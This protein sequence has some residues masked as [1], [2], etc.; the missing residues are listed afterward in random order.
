VFGNTAFETLAS[1]DQTD[2][3]DD[4][5]KHRK[6][7]KNTSSDWEGRYNATLVV[8]IRR[9]HIEKGEIFELVGF[10]GID[11]MKPPDCAPVFCRENRARLEL[12]DILLGYAD[13]I[14]GILKRGTTYSGPN[15]AIPGDYRVDIRNLE[16]VSSLHNFYL[17]RDIPKPVSKSASV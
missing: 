12:K 14:Y 13:N 9:N 6:D 11:C 4:D 15:T 8:P 17:G 5:L 1:S 2:F 7:Y 10:V 3:C 16:F